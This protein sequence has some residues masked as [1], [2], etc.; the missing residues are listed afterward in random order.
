MVT[1]EQLNKWLVLD[2]EIWLETTGASS[3]ELPFGDYLLSDGK[4]FFYGNAW[5]LS[6]DLKHVLTMDVKE[7]KPLM[8]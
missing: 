1:Q 8:R 5:S 2:A 6:Y 4:L 7:K 3:T